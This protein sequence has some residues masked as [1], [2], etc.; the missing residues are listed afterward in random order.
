MD[1]QLQGTLTEWKGSEQLTSSQSLLVLKKKA[2]NIL[3]IKRS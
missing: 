2:N 3:K 1:S